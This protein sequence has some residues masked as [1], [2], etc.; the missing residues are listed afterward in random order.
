MMSTGLI[1]IFIIYI[2][3]G[4][5]LVCLPTVNKNLYKSAKFK[6]PI[7]VLYILGGVTIISMSFFLVQIIADVFL[8]TLGGIA[9]GTLVY[10]SGRASGKKE[11]FDYKAR[12]EQD[13]HLLDT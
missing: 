13:Y 5:A 8:W 3:Q 12:M 10:V 6:P 1:G 11:G 4:T 7:W 9:L 2:M